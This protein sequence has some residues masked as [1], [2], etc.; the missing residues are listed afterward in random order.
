VKATQEKIIR[1]AAAVFGRTGAAFSMRKVAEEASISLGNLQY[2]FK[3]KNDLMAGMLSFYT[4]A[5]QARVDSFVDTLPRNNKDAAG[6]A[7]T[8][9]L[10]DLSSGEFQDLDRVIL[11]LYNSEKGRTRILDDYY[12]RIYRLIFLVLQSIAPD[13]KVSNLHIAASIV[14]PFMESYSMVH[15]SLGASGEEIVPAFTDMI[16]RLLQE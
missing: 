10:A 14:L 7:L 16:W 4:D 15:G 3:T 12:R 8:V 5:F 9:I 2:H 11:S 1:A 6:R 13:A